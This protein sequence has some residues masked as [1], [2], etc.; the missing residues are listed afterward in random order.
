[1]VFKARQLANL[2]T[3]HCRC[4]HFHSQKLRYVKHVLSVVEGLFPVGGGSGGVGVM[5]GQWSAELVE[6]GVLGWLLGWLVW[7]SAE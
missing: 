4:A 7:C 1:M 3:N 5:L 2:V 6:D